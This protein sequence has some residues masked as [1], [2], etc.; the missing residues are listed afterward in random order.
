MQVTEDHAFWIDQMGV[1]TSVCR[2]SKQGAASRSAASSQPDDVFYLLLDELKDALLK[3]G[4]RKAVTAQRRA[5]MARFAEIVPPLTLGEP[6]PM[7]DDPFVDALIVRML[8]P[9]FEPPREPDILRGLPASPG[10]VRGVAKVVRSLSEASKLQEGDIMVCEM[11]V[12]PW[13]PLFST[14]SAVVADTG[15]ILSHCAIVAREYKLPAVSAPCSA[16]ATI[17]DG[18]TITVDGSKGVVRIESR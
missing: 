17:R 16:R 11:T 1:N 4:D 12:P 14:V 2:H 9:V 8:G 7:S 6:P 3:G 13:T 15:G 18:M 5:E 10:V